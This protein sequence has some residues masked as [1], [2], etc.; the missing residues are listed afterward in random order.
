MKSI[1]HCD[2][3]TPF[4]L[5]RIVGITRLFYQCCLVTEEC[6][7][8]RCKRVQVVR[9]RRSVKLATDLVLKLSRYQLH[10]K[11]QLKH[12][13]YRVKGDIF[14]HMRLTAYNSARILL[15]LSTSMSTNFIFVAQ[16][17]QQSILTLDIFIT[18]IVVQLQ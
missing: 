15:T 17:L 7:D 8:W 3:I 14:I 10:N 6:H 5:K 12:P 4:P 18:F 1:R 2:V 9:T 13:I 11:H 16:R